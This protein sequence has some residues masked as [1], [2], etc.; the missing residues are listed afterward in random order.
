MKTEE[1][2]RTLPQGPLVDQVTHLHALISYLVA[3][4]P[5]M[6][7]LA[8]AE[9]SLREITRQSATWPPVQVSTPRPPSTD[10]Y[11]WKK[12]RANL[13]T[14]EATLSE[15]MAK[16]GRNLKAAQEA[17]RARLT[18]EQRDQASQARYT[19]A[20]AAERRAGLAFVASEVARVRRELGLQE[21]DQP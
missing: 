15:S 19:R 4:G 13:R 8:N 21:V 11:Y 10:A 6:H 14:A 7:V 5:P 16:L 3:G 12:I 9:H 17:R 20:M 1:F 2:R 18:P